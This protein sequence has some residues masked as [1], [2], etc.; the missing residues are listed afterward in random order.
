MMHLKNKG[1]YLLS[2]K[3]EIFT[4]TA[5]HK[6]VGRQIIVSEWMAD[7]LF[8]H[9]F[10][11]QEP[12]E[13]KRIMYKSMLRVQQELRWVRFPLSFLVHTLLVY[14][15]LAFT[16]SSSN[17]NFSSLGQ[18]GIAGYKYYREILWALVL[19]VMPWWN[20]IWESVCETLKHA[21]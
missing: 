8:S 12:V 18:A 10:L 20:K 9:R 17:E 7:W 16:A 4:I 2:F 19:S 1:S 14:K 21:D 13:N 11:V 6:V 15:L 5:A 3:G